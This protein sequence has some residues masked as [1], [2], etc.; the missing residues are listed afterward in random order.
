MS[1]LRFQ[2]CLLQARQRFVGSPIIFVLIPLVAQLL[3]RLLTS[4][5]CCKRHIADYHSSIWPEIL[6]HNPLD[7][8]NLGRVV[9]FVEHVR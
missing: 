9:E 1:V 2:P 3:E 8:S 5:S 7:Q 4:L 6:P